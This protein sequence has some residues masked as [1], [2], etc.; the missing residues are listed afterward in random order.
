MYVISFSVF[1]QPAG[2]LSGGLNPEGEND[3]IRPSQGRRAAGP[4]VGG[5]VYGIDFHADDYA[6]T[7]G[8]SER[9]LSL[10]RAGRIDS[11]S[12]LINMGC[13][14]ECMALL[15]ENWDSLPRKPL[16]S[17]HINL[18]D[19]FRLSSPDGKT[20]LHNSWTR[21]FLQSVLPWKREKALAPL[22]AE[23]GAQLLAFR[24]LTADLKDD[25]GA[26]IPFRIDSHVHTHM[27]P[28]VFDALIDALKRTGLLG[29]VR[30]IRCTA[31]PLSPFLFTPGVT[32]TV[33]PVNILK[34][35]ILQLLG[36]S[37]RKKL[38]RLQ[39][40]TCRVFGLAMTGNMDLK[41]V[42][43]ILPKMERYARRK[44]VRLEVLSH[45]GR[46]AEA[47]LTEEYGPDDRK[48][49]PSPKRD[50]EYRMLMELKRG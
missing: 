4:P 42:S 15:R 2:R 5:T 23:I 48:A 3:I 11:V 25:E 8:N 33:P 12:V 46:S 39:V 22:S 49:F 17:A 24:K 34:N 50:V 32:G 6:A 7:P 31:E 38:S 13:C 28:L 14:G 47:E 36:H 37:V 41:R 43:L 18:I 30:F 16:L 35:L 44:D 26:P 1:L 20:V 21:L 27:I 29:E 19:G 9:I 40:D 45:P 10:L